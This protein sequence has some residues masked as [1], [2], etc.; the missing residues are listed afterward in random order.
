MP[1]L[2]SKPF[3][4][5]WGEYLKILRHSRPRCTHPEPVVRMGRPVAS[6]DS[7]TVLAP[8][9]AKGGLIEWF[10]GEFDA[11]NPEAASSLR[12][13]SKRIG[14]SGAA[15]YPRTLPA[16]W[17]QNLDTIIEGLAAIDIAAG[18]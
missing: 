10:V 12:A 6:L 16:V 5:L 17:T 3:P 4:A 7:R 13:L 2:L 1:T 8:I 15:K 9:P 11:R 18:N 14:D